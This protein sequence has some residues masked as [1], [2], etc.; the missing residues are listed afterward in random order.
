MA[1]EQLFPAEVKMERPGVRA[2]K[3][4]LPQKPKR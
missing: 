1:L 4:L 2:E 3:L